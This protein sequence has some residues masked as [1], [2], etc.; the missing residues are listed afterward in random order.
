VQCALTIYYIA[1][2]GS[3][4]SLLAVQGGGN[5]G[6]FNVYVVKDRN[7]RSGAASVATVSCVEGASTD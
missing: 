5:D 6:A 1:V 2:A 4:Q 3:R 7:D